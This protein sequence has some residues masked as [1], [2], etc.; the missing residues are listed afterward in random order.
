MCCLLEWGAIP[1]GGS[2]QNP[3]Q[4][5]IQGICPSYHPLVMP[6]DLQDCKNT[7]L[8]FEAYDTRFLWNLHFKPVSAHQCSFYYLP[9]RCLIKSASWVLESWFFVEVHQIWLHFSVTV[10]THA[11][12]IPALLIFMVRF[13]KWH[14]KTLLLTLLKLLWGWLPAQKSFMNNCIYVQLLTGA[15]QNKSSLY[16]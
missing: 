3:S 16:S 4:H 9:P 2:L 5:S 15:A 11:L 10:D 6:L 7:A 14:P 12:H 1:G 8:E 13:Y